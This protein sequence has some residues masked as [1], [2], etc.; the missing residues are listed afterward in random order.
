MLLLVTLV[1]TARVP[2]PNVEILQPKDLDP[3]TVNLIP[4]PTSVQFTSGSFLLQAG[5]SILF[6]NSTLIDAATLLAADILKLKLVFLTVQPAPR[7]TVP[8]SIVLVIDP[9]ISARIPVSGADDTNPF[10]P[11]FEDGSYKLEVTSN[12]V[13]ITGASVQG[14]IHGTV[15]LIQAISSDS[16]VPNMIVLDKPYRRYRGLSIDTNTD[17]Q[18]SMG[19]LKSMIDLCRFYKMSI[20]TFNTGREEWIGWVMDSISQMNATYRNGGASGCYTG[21]CY[22]Q[23][24]DE[25]ADLIRYGAQRGVRLIPYAQC[26][27]NDPI[28]IN[29]LK[30]K[31]NPDTPYADFMDEIDHAGPSTFNGTADDRFWKFMTIVKARVFE[32]FSIGWPSGKLPL[33]N[34][35]P[36][37][38]EGGMD[39]ITARRFFDILKEIDPDV[40][41]QFWNGLCATCQDD[42][43]PLF[44]VRDQILVNFYTKQYSESD[45]YGYI[46]SG[47]HV[48]NTA[49][50]P[51]YVLG[52]TRLGVQKNPSDFHKVSATTEDVEGDGPWTVA[53]TWT[54][55]N[56]YRTGTDG[57]FNI[58]LV[59]WDM[60]QNPSTD[61][62]TVGAQL[63]TWGMGS[64]T[65]FEYVRSRLAALSEHSWNYQTWPYAPALETFTTFNAT[66]SNS[67]LICL[68]LPE[69]LRSLCDQT[70][71]D[72]ACRI[73]D[74]NGSCGASD[75]PPGRPCNPSDLEAAC[76]K[77]PGCWAVNSNG[78]VKRS[79]DT[80]PADPNTQLLVRN[81]GN[82][83]EAFDEWNEGF[84]KL[85][86]IVDLLTSHDLPPNIPSGYS[87]GGRI[88]LT[89]QGVLTNFS[90]ASDTNGIAGADAVCRMFAGHRFKAM[91]TDEDGC[92]GAPCRRATVTPNTGDGQIDW[93]LKPKAA[94][95][96]LD[97]T[98]LVG[99]TGANSLFEWPL[100][101]NIGGAFNQMTGMHGDWTTWVNGTCSSYRC[102]D[103]T[104]QQAIGWAAGLTAQLLQGAYDTSGCGVNRFIC[105]EV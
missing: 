9:S 86:Q 14:V 42:S 70:C 25:M 88:F 18:H 19:N 21:A 49:W 72:Y 8:N 65:E 44:P 62:L 101:T 87:Y 40:K 47:W 54:H 74:R 105:V 23:S 90:D 41:I 17:N 33:Y 78:Y 5:G 98:T 63:C 81:M 95:F 64:P 66:D 68:S 6:K 11:Q 37:L 43:H 12:G 24:R 69:D 94:Y 7:T 36:V 56:Y 27:P 82:V 10:I 45:I 59:D 30:T 50:A 93:V 75:S 103:G 100:L 52:L 22:F 53:E 38:G 60:F 83:S 13:T 104:C 84:E 15:T 79:T 20:L 2:R 99:T 89:T 39:D 97:N 55:F 51:L 31:Y 32:L 102:A 35:G 48:L 92:N 26:T 71:T 4:R 57:S 58:S 46:N 96:H 1:L 76:L 91:L 34:I 73:G 77:I 16:T 80:S 28:L 3:P 29:A 85:D 61:S 67:N